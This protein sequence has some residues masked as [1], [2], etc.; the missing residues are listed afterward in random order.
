MT[1]N[2]LIKKLTEQFKP[3][4]RKDIALVVQTVLDSMIDALKNNE[5]IEIRGFGTFTLRTRRP[6][7]GRNP[8]TGTPVTLGDRRVA[9]FKTGKELKLMVDG[10]K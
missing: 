5:R 1:K 4:S 3:Y 9:F 10:K 8:K 7:M 6:R 2:E